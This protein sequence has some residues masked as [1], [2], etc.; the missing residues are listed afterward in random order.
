MKTLPTPRLIRLLFNNTFIAS[1]TS[2]LFVWE[3]PYYPQYYLPASSLLSSTA[4]NLTLTRGEAIHNPADKTLIAHTYTLTVG[5][6]STSACVIFEPNLPSP[7][8]ALSGL[9]KVDFNAM[10]KWFEESTPIAVHP[11]DPFKRI[12]ILQSTR[13]VQVFIS[14]VRVAD[15]NNTMHLYETGL[16]ARFYMPLTDVDVGVLRRSGTRTLCPYK[17]E[18]EYYSVELGEGKV[19]EDVVWYYERP[20]LESARIEGEFVFLFFSW[21]LGFVRWSGVVGC[22]VVL[23]VHC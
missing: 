6:K 10:D 19:W 12:D 17:G 3:H 1:T 16:P 5:A 4:P 11:K 7:G 18:A 14:G 13:R 22:C 23:V 21:V 20:T 2:A 8:S 15:S 9:A